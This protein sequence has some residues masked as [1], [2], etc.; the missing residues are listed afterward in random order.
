MKGFKDKS[1]QC[2]LE[3]GLFFSF[4]SDHTGTMALLSLNVCDFVIFGLALI[5]DVI[6]L[7]CCRPEGGVRWKVS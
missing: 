4:L 1:N 5:F 3:L 6:P 7:A 2:R